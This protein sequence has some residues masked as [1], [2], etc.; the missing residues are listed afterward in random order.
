MTK[1]RD[2][3]ELIQ[4]CLDREITVDENISL[5][6]HLSQ[7]EDCQALYDGLVE[8]EQEIIGL[9]Q[10]VPNHN[11]NTR[12]LARIAVKKA[13]TWV[14]AIIILGGVSLASTL[15][16]L[17][18]SLGSDIFNK[19]LFSS[20]AIVRFIDKLSFICSTL[21]RILSPLAKN[22]FNP[23]MCVIGLAL[24]IGMF[25]LFGKIFT[26]KEIICTV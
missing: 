24:S 14:K 15:V 13:P 7:C 18:S 8:T 26:K 1:H 19:V 25:I 22:Q 9:T 20:P 11:F 17:F 2:I 12:V 6:L 16:L 5:Q 3:E 10:L 21:S 23:T 4:K